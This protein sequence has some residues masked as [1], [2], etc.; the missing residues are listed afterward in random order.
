[1]S[2]C[3][4][5]KRTTIIV[6]GNSAANKTE[7]PLLWEDVLEFA[8]SIER[9]C[10]VP[11]PHRCVRKTRAYKQWQ[12]YASVLRRFVLYLKADLPISVGMAA[13]FYETKR[14]GERARN[15]LLEKT[16]PRK[17]GY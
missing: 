13:A 7:P 6:F 10:L 12:R 11:W 5:V 4:E 3:K 16:P 1:M 8:K 2:K 17:R 9:Q 14:Q 15:V